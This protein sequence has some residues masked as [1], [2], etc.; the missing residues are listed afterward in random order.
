[1]TELNP[2]SK[3]APHDLIPTNPPN[4]YAYKA[5]CVGVYDG[6]TITVQIDC[7]FSITFKQKIRLYGIDTPELRGKERTTGLEV[8]DWVRH[9]LLHKPIW[10]LTYKDRTGKYGRYLAQVF[11]QKNTGEWKNLNRELIEG[12][13]AIPYMI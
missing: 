6:D 9:L 8:R 7:G 1:M 5:E 11:Y 4:L 2:L 12:G 3:L 13:M 10:L